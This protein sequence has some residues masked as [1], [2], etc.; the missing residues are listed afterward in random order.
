MTTSGKTEWV[1]AISDESKP[2]TARHLGYFRGSLRNNLYAE[3]LKLFAAKSKTNF[4]RADLARRLNRRPEQITRWFSGPGNLR[5]DTLSDLLLAMG[6]ELEI[7]VRPIS[8]AH[9]EG[10]PVSAPKRAARG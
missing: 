5:L 6:H 3:I 1:T 7:T 2:L 8:Q 10:E 4:T 9:A